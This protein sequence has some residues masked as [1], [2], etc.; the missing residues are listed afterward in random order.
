MQ[1]IEEDIL[2]KNPATDC[3]TQIRYIILAP[4]E[5]DFDQDTIPIIDQI[6]EE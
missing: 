1:S 4:S 6:I 5:I 3:V 2:C